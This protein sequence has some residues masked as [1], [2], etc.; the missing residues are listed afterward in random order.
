MDSMLNTCALSPA[1]TQ[2]ELE[3]VRS[4]HPNDHPT[5]MPSRTRSPLI[6]SR[7]RKPCLH[8]RDQL[9]MQIEPH[10][11]APSRSSSSSRYPPLPGVLAVLVRRKLHFVHA[12]N[13]RNTAA[14]VC[15]SAVC[16]CRWIWNLLDESLCLSLRKRVLSAVDS[17]LR[18]C[19]RLGAIPGCHRGVDWIERGAAG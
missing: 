7:S 16:H 5:W 3:G 10:R 4:K 17:R 2:V 18:S 13:R 1:E 15:H 8:P 11:G 9:D 12:N 6:E 14:S 19:M